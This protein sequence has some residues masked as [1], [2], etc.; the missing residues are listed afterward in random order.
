MQCKVVAP[1]VRLRLFAQRRSQTFVKKTAACKGGLGILPAFLLA[2]IH[3]GHNGR[4]QFAPKSI[5]TL[6]QIIILNVPWQFRH[7]CEWK[8]LS[9]VRG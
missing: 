4:H 5:F 6:N 7:H 8:A 2:T 1:F 9:R 3:T